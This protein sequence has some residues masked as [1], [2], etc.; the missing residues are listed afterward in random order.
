MHR[1]S[2]TEM[3]CHA[4]VGRGHAAPIAQPERKPDIESE[5]GLDN[6]GAKPAGAR[7]LFVAVVSAA[8]TCERSIGHHVRFRQCPAF[9]FAC[10][11]AGMEVLQET[12][13]VQVRLERSSRPQLRRLHFAR[14]RRVRPA[15]Q[16]M[17]IRNNLIIMID[18]PEIGPQIIVARSLSFRSLRPPPAAQSRADRH[19]LPIIHHE[20]TRT[21]VRVASP[22]A[23]RGIKGK[24]TER[25]TGRQQS[26]GNAAPTLQRGAEM[27][28]Q[29]NATVIADQTCEG[30]DIVARNGTRCGFA[31]G[32]AWVGRR[33]LDACRCHGISTKRPATPRD[34]SSRCAS[35]ARA[36]GRRS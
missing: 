1:P 14:R 35:D 6:A 24:T 13:L 23:P 31:F 3:T 20:G 18:H 10:M 33:Q 34:S 21:R 32:H 16:Y 29:M 28:V 25:P 7:E 17:T 4:A 22:D 12:D 5:H 27:F 11:A 8:V 19:R 36:S 2:V 30:A 9:G 26:M 15:H